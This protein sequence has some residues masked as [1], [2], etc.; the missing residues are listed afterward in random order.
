[1][2]GVMQGYRKFET[3]QYNRILNLELSDKTRKIS[4]HFDKVSKLSKL[5]LYTLQDNLEQYNHPAIPFYCS[6]ILPSAF[7]PFFFSLVALTYHY[8]VGYSIVQPL[9]SL[10]QHYWTFGKLDTG[11]SHQWT[12]GK[13]TV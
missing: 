6:S 10:T 3:V 5:F 11:L 9:D 1:M 7:G 2:S 4:Q 12:V 8:T 13:S